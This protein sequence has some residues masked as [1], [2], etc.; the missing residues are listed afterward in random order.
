LSSDEV[1]VRS[2]NWRFLRWSLLAACGLSALNLF[3]YAP[4]GWRSPQHSQFTFLAAVISN[5]IGAIVIGAGA[6]MAAPYATTRWRAGLIG[7]PLWL[8]VSQIAYWLLL[9]ISMTL[10]QFIAFCGISL[11]IGFIGGFVLWEEN[12]EDLR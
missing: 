11:I 4:N 9:R 10:R 6:D 8:A 12:D 1:N 3:T 5:F 2:K 7:A